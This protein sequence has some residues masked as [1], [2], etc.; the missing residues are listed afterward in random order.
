MRLALKAASGL[1]VVV[2]AWTAAWGVQD[3]PPDAT[4]SGPVL[5]R[6]VA[7]PDFLN[8][9]VGD[10][11]TLPTW[12]EGD[13]NSW[14]PFL[15]RSIEVVLDEVAAAGPDSVLVTGDLVEGHW[16]RD[17]DDTGI[18]GPSRTDQQRTAMLRRAGHFYHST[19]VERFRERGLELHAAVGDHDVGDDP[20]RGPRWRFKRASIPAYKQLFGRYHTRAPDSG[21]RYPDRPVGTPWADAAYA[22]QL[23]PDVLLVT[24]DVFHVTRNDVRIEVVGGQLAWLRNTLRA[25]QE[26]GTR[27]VVVQGHTPIVTPVRTRM[28]SA[29][30]LRGGTD[31]ALWRTLAEYDV[32]LYLAGE[33]HD[34]SMQQEDG[35]T[36]VATGGLLYAGDTSYLTADVYD[37]RVVLDV[38]EFDS[39][40]HAWQGD[41]WQ[42]GAY[43]TF[44]HVEIEPGSHSVGELVL[45]DDGSVLS[46]S[47]KLAEYDG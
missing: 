1:T 17:V 46:A 32:D 22:V 8:Q 18:F 35:V 41:L 15:E 19:Y 36:Q 34:T 23:S 38:R 2:L 4:P 12:H 9:D 14:T 21:P 31:S 16:L 33:V 25:A 10:V 11:R 28:S 29:L 20:F 47:G 45:L 27:W 26:R 13:P 24:V 42:L 39:V 30:T 37:D 3:G 6:F 44:G 43:R 40:R 5:Y 7:M